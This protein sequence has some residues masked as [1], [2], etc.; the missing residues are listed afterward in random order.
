MSRSIEKDQKDYTAA[1]EVGFRL[2]QEANPEADGEELRK[3]LLDRP[4]ALWQKRLNHPS[5]S[6]LEA[7]LAREGLPLSD[8]LRV[9]WSG[10]EP[11]REQ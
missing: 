9:W 3:H 7:A 4:N 2:I 10:L 1:I 6:D 8:K 11:S 5:I